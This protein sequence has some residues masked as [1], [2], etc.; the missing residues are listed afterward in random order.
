MAHHQ[1]AGAAAGALWAKPSCHMTIQDIPYLSEASY[2]IYLPAI[3]VAQ[4]S[5]KGSSSKS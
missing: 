2:M 3:D 4:W 5:S 1:A